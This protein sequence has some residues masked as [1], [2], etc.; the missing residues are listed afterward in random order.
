MLNTRLEKEL[1]TKRRKS[2]SSFKSRMT[3][4]VGCIFSSIEYDAHGNMI[5]P[6]GKQPQLLNVVSLYKNKLFYSVK[7]SHDLVKIQVLETVSDVF[8]KKQS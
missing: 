7:F 8:L 3:Q 2:K 1:L 4:H 6:V 5:T